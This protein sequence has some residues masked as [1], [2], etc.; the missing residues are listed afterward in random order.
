MFNL[1]VECA[2]IFYKLHDFE[3]T[4]KYLKFSFSIYDKIKNPHFKI[5]LK[6]VSANN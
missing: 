3:N 4:E 5:L 2:E 6:Y 1:N